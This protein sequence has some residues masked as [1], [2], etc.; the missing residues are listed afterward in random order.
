M[1]E[2]ECFKAAFL[3]T[4]ELRVNSAK[5]YDKEIASLK[6]SLQGKE[7]EIDRLKSEY[8]LITK[9][10]CEKNDLKLQEKEQEIEVWRNIS[11]KCYCAFCSD[12]IE[13]TWEELKSHMTICK[14][15]PLFHAY[16]EIELL[17]SSLQE[18]EQEIEKLKVEVNEYGFN[19]LKAANKSIKAEN[20]KIY[21]MLENLEKSNDLLKS[22][23]PDQE[24]L[25][26]ILEIC[27]K[28]DDDFFIKSLQ[29]RE[30]QFRIFRSFLES[31]KTT[32][33]EING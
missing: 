29:R 9:S 18:K 33:G 31:L 2:I 1:K 5:R 27:N 8:T 13:R 15:H 14:S 23:L 21:S 10:F 7:E 24:E 16:Q 30:E 11:E 4:D 6:T 3:T 20:D 26:R 28:L 19:N 32:N 17:K 22:K 12:N 25:G